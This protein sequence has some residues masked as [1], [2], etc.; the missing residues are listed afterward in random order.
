MNCQICQTELEDL[1]YGELDAMRAAAITEHLSVCSDCR[2][3]QMALERENEIFAAFY[4]QTAL[5]PADEMWQ[6]IHAR[7]KDNVEQ[8]ASL[9]SGWKAR[10]RNFFV[11]LLAPVMLRQVGLAAL[12]VLV[13]VGL[14]ALFFSMRNNENEVAVVSP[15]PTP[16]AISSPRP[17]PSETPKATSTPDVKEAEKPQPALSKVPKAESK[18]AVTP[19]LSENELLMQ[20]IA[21]ATREYQGAIKLLERT[22]ARRKTELDEATI[23]QFEGSLAMIDASIAASRQAM[24]T[25]PNDPT[26]ARYLLAAYSKKV[27]LMQEIA[28][29]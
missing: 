18:P 3:V 9:Q 14:T 27:E 8:A 10:L 6:A 19:K 11:P 16:S 4:E 22:I 15:S 5:E 7:I 17:A 2:R 25:H 29:R 12:L 13:S 26:P 23:K 1:L 28:M 24:Q 20:Q 21:K